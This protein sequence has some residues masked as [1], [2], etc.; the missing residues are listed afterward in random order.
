M[1]LAGGKAAKLAGKVDDT[2]AGKS[3]VGAKGEARLLQGL[4]AGT[5]TALAALT[6]ANVMEG[7]DGAMVAFLPCLSF[8]LG[9]QC[10]GGRDDGTGTAW[11]S[12]AAFLRLQR[13][14]VIANFMIQMNSMK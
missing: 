8:L 9:L 7:T 14:T 13:G 4:V 3:A 12:F 5:A 10:R 6:A 1:M 11:A 2:G